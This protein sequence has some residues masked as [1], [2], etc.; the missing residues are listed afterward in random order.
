MSRITVIG[1]GY[2]G[3]ANVLFLAKNNI[4]T[5][6]DISA[7][8]ISMLQSGKSYIKEELIE[9]EL[10]T[11]TAIF[12]IDRSCYKN[13]DYFF[14]AAPTNYNEDTNYFDMSI[15]TG[16]IAEIL[17]VNNNCKIIIKSTVPIGYTEQVKKQFSYKNIIFMPEFLREGTSL[18]DCINPDRIIIGG[19]EIV[20]KDIADLFSGCATNN[21][22]YM[23]STEAE[24]VK[25]FA[26]NYLAMRVAFFNELDT[27]ASVNNLSSK[28][29][30]MGVSTDKRIGNQYNN[31]SFGYGGYCFPKDTKQLTANYKN[32]PQ[33]IISAIVDSNE[34]RKDFIVGDILSK[35]LKN[36]GIYKLAMKS[37]SDNSRYSAILDIMKKLKEN[38]VECIIY[39][40]SISDKY[41]FDCKVETDFNK[42]LDSID[43][44]ITN[45]VDDK[46]CKITKPI[47][48]RDIFHNN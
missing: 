5:G 47:Y 1:L 9:Q 45:R 20:N 14:I 46:I 8:K 26:N 34:T 17:E 19:D 25:L 2:V 22:L 32:I 48:T 31:P 29:I 38:N 43:M 30:I 42:F 27:Y 40:N 7:D 39:D 18:L 36:V 21:I 15:V 41:I 23:S 6:I 11:T 28:N 33:N 24:A 4:V 13:T 10:L 44:V 3:L 16:I 12:T 37:N 35:G